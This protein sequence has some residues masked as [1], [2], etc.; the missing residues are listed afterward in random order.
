MCWV[1]PSSSPRYN[2][3]FQEVLALDPKPFGPDVMA[4]E[5]AFYETQANAYVTRAFVVCACCLMK[6]PRVYYLSTS[7]HF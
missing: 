3:L 4:L 1:P 6:T 5:S 7:V 2:L